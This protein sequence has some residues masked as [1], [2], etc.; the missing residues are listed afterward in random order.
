MTNARDFTTSL[1]RRRAGAHCPGC[2]RFTTRWDSL[3]RCRDCERPKARPGPRPV[4]S[5]TTMLSGYVMLKTDVGWVAEHR[6]V[7][8]GMLGRRLREGENIHHIN[9]V[10]DDNRPDNLELW[11]TPPRAGQKV[12]DLIAWMV[13]GYREQV[14]A[15]LGGYLDPTLPY[16]PRSTPTS[17]KRES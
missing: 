17:H 14:I 3:A 9:G 15:A 1:R 16:G 5:R 11:V 6:S 10:R 8:E 4:G 2:E 13:E 12:A 7:M